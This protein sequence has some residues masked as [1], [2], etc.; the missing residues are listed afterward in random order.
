MLA[1]EFLPGHS[2]Q[3]GRLGQ[4]FGLT[5]IG[6]RSSAGDQAGDHLDL[7][8]IARQLP[9]CNCDYDYSGPQP[10]RETGAKQSDGPRFQLTLLTRPVTD[11]LSLSDY[12]PGWRSFSTC[13][14]ICKLPC[15]Y[16]LASNRNRQRTGL[17]VNSD[18][19]TRMRMRK[20]E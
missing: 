7:T 8:T 15:H 1:I 19:A 12:L 5:D 4:D 16:L 6:R 2:R 9:D 13:C 11:S 14:E 18:W 3:A 17:D 10:R 20:E